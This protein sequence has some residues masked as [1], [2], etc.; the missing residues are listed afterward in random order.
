MSEIERIRAAAAHLENWK[1]VKSSPAPARRQPDA[2]QSLLTSWP[3]AR[4]LRLLSRAAATSS[5]AS[6]ERCNE[7]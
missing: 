2:L 5:A 3:G 1:L 7:K 4:A 6:E